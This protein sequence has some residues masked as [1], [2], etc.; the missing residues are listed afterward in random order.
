MSA[1]IASDLSR[2]DTASKSKLSSRSSNELQVVVDEADGLRVAERTPF[3]LE[4]ERDAL[5]GRA[6]DQRAQSRPA[7]V[8]LPFE[9]EQPG[10]EP[11]ATATQENEQR[12][13]WRGA[14]QR[15]R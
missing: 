2:F 11:D 8:P 15:Q 14:E 7:A 9:R 5:V 10:L 3:E 12:G 13:H 6:D 1:R 4:R